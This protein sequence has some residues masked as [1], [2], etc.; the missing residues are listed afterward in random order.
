MQNKKMFLLIVVGVVI[1][2]AAVVYRLY[3]GARMVTPIE[4]P[5]KIEATNPKNA[6]YSIDGQSVTLVNGISSTPAAPGSASMVTTQYFGNEVTHDFDGDGR[7]D[8]VFILTQS[9]GGSGT[10]YYVVA[11]LNTASGYIG[12]A[13]LLLGDRIAPQ[14]TA[15]SQ[16]KA[17]PDVIV[18][19]YAD[20]KAGEAF[21]VQPSVGKSVWLKLDLQTMQFGEVAQNFEG[22]ADPGKMTLGMKTWNWVNTTYNNDTTVKPKT[23]K[24]ALTFKTNGT[25]SATTDCNGVGGEYALNGN[26]ITFTKMVSTMM[27]CEGSQEQE[28]SKMLSQVQNYLFTSKGELVLNLKL[29]SGMMVFK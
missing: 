16:N 12:S 18:V 15:M 8:T 29:D 4:N 9:T 7:Q 19:N 24:F 17:T 11:A 21:T 10:F 2:G 25:F 27:Y 13:G 14:T 26:K 1:I 20:R 6:T 5:E 3:P 28:Y 22:E 23:N